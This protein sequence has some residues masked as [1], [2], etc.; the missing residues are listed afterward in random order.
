MSIGEVAI[1][2]ALIA[3]GVAYAVVIANGE[4]AEIEA[5]DRDPFGYVRNK[6]PVSVVEV[7]FGIF[8]IG[9]VLLGF[10]AMFSANATA[11][12]V[13]SV[14]LL[15]GV[16]IAA[17][18]ALSTN[19]A[20]RARSEDPTAVSANFSPP[21]SEVFALVIAIVGPLSGLAMHWVVTVVAALAVIGSVVYALREV[22][23]M[24][25]WSSRRG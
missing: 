5:R 18:D 11:G 19:S 12:A 14:V 4:R 22:G 6:L 17:F 20:L 13:F 7:L 8:L 1:I 15:V 2:L 25:A 16:G 23:A 24:E 10:G 9:V 21:L 3:A